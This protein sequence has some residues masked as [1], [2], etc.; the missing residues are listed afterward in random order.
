[1]NFILIFVLTIKYRGVQVVRVA[2][3]HASSLR[4]ES[5][6]LYRIFG[7]PSSL[8][9]AGKE[10]SQRKDRK[11][12]DT[13]ENHGRQEFLTWSIE[14]KLSTQIVVHMSITNNLFC[15]WCIHYFMIYS[16]FGRVGRKNV[17]V[18]QDYP[19]FPKIPQISLEV[20]YFLP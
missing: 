9:S 15:K 3:W 19:K 14:I 6:C 13:M 11:E 10:Y 16:I 2:A 7:A 17:A 1:M 12:K 4:F 8:G 5:L 20:R 18:S